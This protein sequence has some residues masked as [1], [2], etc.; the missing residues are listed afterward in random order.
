MQIEQMNEN[1]KLIL[2]DCIEVMETMVPADTVITDPPY[3]IADVWKGG[4]GRGWGKARADTQER[5]EW[6]VKPSQETIDKILTMGKQVIIWGGNYFT[7][8]ISR[9]W[10]IWNKPERGFSLSEAE[11]AWT[12]RDAPMRVFDC[13]RSDT[14]REHPT[15]K[16][17]SLM[18][19]CLLNFSNEG[20]LIF[21]PYMGS[22]TT[23]VACAQ[24]N[25]RFTG[26]EISKKYFDL[27]RRR[28]GDALKQPRLF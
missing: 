16:P 25:R 18:N 1:T 19:W 6:D 5:N 20:D 28:V 22:G 24:N 9:G 11:L 7:L 17:V 14:G 12:N 21:D 3:G 8:P 15:Q 23:G 10:L 13:H 26:V 4:F 27:A 2:G